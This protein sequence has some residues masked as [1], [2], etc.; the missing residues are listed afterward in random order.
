M[1][2][3][4]TRTAERCVKVIT[5]KPQKTPDSTIVTL[6]VEVEEVKTRAHVFVTGRVH[7]VFFRAETKRHA[8]QNDV[9]GWVR[10]VPDGRVEAVFEGDV[11]AVEEV[12]V[13]CK[14]GSKHARVT[15][16]YVKWESFTGEFD[17]FKI[18]YG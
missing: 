8:G 9:K 13:F 12:I 15:G 5:L 17:K 7:G 4:R 3:R 2:K 10:N 14:R 18:K 6:E 11:E 1:H 16:T